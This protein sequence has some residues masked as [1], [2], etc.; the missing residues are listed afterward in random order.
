VALERLDERIQEAG[1]AKNGP[2]AP[3]VAPTGGLDA[4]PARKDRDQDVSR[5]GS[6]REVSGSCLEGELIVLE[7]TVAHDVEA[8]EESACLLTLASAS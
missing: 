3:V 5:R 7:S 8:L 2:R 6:R 1:D 4:C